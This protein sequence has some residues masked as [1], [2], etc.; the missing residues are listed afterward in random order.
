MRRDDLILIGSPRPA[1]GRRP[2]RL[3]PARRVCCPGRAGSPGSSSTRS[4]RPPTTASPSDAPA[5]SSGSPAA[6]SASWTPRDRR[7]AVISDLDLAPRNERG[8]VEY[9][10]TFT[11]WQ[12]TDPAKASGVL[13]YAVPNRGQSAVL[14]RV[15]R[16]RRAGRRL[17]LPSRRRHSDERL[18][19]R[20][21]RCGRRDDHRPGGEE[22]RRFQHHRPGACTFRQHAG[23]YKDALTPLGERAGRSRYRAGDPHAPGRRGRRRHSDRPGDWAFADC[24]SVRSPARRTRR[25]VREGRVRPGRLYELV[26]TAKD[27][28]GAR[29]RAG[30]DARHRVVLP[31]CGEGRRR[32]G[33]PDPADRCRTS[34][35][36]SRSRAISSAR[37]SISASTRTST[38][39]SSGTGPTRTSPRARSR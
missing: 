8:M 27:P 29:H 24:R 5:I 3:V 1:A 10:A 21:R 23:R 11:L 33:E 38:A 9:V 2:G 34:S 17:L 15:P 13:I 20:R 22:R 28:L 35:P 39:A 31:V 30:G 16:R 26:Y 18:A 36:A 14:P 37:S 7:N 6:C 4:G 19:G 32:H 25:A 12:P